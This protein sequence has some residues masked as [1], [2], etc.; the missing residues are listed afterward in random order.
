MAKK[1]KISVMTI[2]CIGVLCV[3]IVFF[4]LLTTK[5]EKLEGLVSKQN[6]YL[7]HCTTALRKKGQAKG[8]QRCIGVTGT[9]FGSGSRGQ[10][11]GWNQFKYTDTDNTG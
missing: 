5:S 9:R 2:L 10:N 8:R 3:G 1:T 11:W 7:Q 4:N 6:K